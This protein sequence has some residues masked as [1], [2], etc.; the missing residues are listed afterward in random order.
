MAKRIGTMD[1][2]AQALRL[3]GRRF[4]RDLGGPI[5]TLHLKN[6]RSPG[7]LN[8]PVNADKGIPLQGLKIMDGRFVLGS[9]ALDVG[10]HGDPWSVPAPSPAYAEK[11]HG[12]GWLYDLSSLSRSRALLKKNPALKAQIRTRAGMLVDRW[13]D[14]YG[15]WNPFAWREDILTERLFAWLVN[16]QTLLQTD[17]DALTTTKRETSLM[18]QLVMLRKTWRQTPEGIVR[19]RAL[20][21]LVVGACGFAGRQEVW[22]D[23]ALDQLDDE[24]E[25]QILPDGGHVSRRPEAVLEALE[26]LT[27][28]ESALDINSLK[29]SKEIRRAIDRLAP[30]L[31]FFSL[32]DKNLA[33]FNGGGTGEVNQIKH[34]AKRTASKTGSFG[35]APHSKFQRLARNETVLLMDV[36][37]APPRPFD[38]QA[39]LAPLAFEMSTTDGPLIVN[40]GWNTDQPQKWKEIVR[41]TAAHSTLIMDNSDAGRLASGGLT[42]RL[43]GPVIVEDCGKVGCKR[44]EQDSGTWL[45]A[46]HG[47]YIKPFGLNHR[48]RIYMDI[49]GFDVRGEDQLAVP[50]GE[51]PLHNGQIPFALRF[52]LHPSVK[53][54]LARDQNSALLIQPGGT[55]WRFRT[56]GGPV[57]LEKSV[58]LSQ[59]TRPQP[60]EQLVI[61]GQAWADGDGEARSN[62]VRWTFKRL[63]AMDKHI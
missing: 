25:R 16:W 49:T 45:E 13:V 18:R 56:D 8:L 10:T 33:A 47:G 4:R 28:V 5:R 44:L 55:G 27:A 32:D 20:A 46:F 40:C 37:N 24:I 34:L 29:G 50:I 31:P 48:R 61:Y 36:G 17:K 9:Q 57:K 23:R 43:F 54:S 19:L 38:R 3:G 7:L 58:W 51:A 2:V 12:F 41:H 52:H 14:V 53:A 35:Y 62:R 63:G 39:H 59:G 11:L 60:C 1:I 6:I 26:I 21:C 22:R 30:M 15:R 42:E